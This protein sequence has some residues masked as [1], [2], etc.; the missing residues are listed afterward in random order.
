MKPK[1]GDPD[2]PGLIEYLEDIIGT[3][4]YQEQIE[5]L[6]QDSEKLEVMR[7]ERGEV[8][9]IVENDLQRLEPSKD[10]AVEYVRKEKQ[11]MQLQNV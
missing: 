9:R 11:G 8:M 5:T 3:S 4:L 1:S 10:K 2:K 6:S 7:R